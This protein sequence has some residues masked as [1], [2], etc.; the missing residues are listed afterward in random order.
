MGRGKRLAGTVIWMADLSDHEPKRLQFDVGRIRVDQ[1]SIGMSGEAQRATPTSM[2]YVPS[3]SDD[4][5][6]SI[7][8]TGQGRGRGSSGSASIFSFLPKHSMPIVQ[9]P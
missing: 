7:V 5:S 8:W 3:S 1:L 4:A 2:G 6:K 9:H